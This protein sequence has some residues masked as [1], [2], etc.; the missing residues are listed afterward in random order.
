M[1]EQWFNIFNDLNVKKKELKELKNKHNDLSNALIDNIIQNNIDSIVIP[2][3]NKKLILN[4]K[5]S[6]GTINKDYILETLNNYIDE[7][8]PKGTTDLAENMTE[9]IMQNR[10]EK[11]KHFLKL[12]KK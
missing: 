4:E 9:S 5:T 2:N 3:S 12:V 11:R 1:E 6:Y 7:K 8:S 10:V